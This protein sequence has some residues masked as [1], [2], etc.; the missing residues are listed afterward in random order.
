MSC[1]LKVRHSSTPGKTMVSV[2][3]CG[4]SLVL[5]RLV[6]EDFPDRNTEPDYERASYFFASFG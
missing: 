3:R 5:A 2:R 6:H 4:P 1:A